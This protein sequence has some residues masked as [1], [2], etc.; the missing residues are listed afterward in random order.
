[1][2]GYSILKDEAG[3]RYKI[4]NN[5]KADFQLLV[6]M[7]KNEDFGT[8]KLNAIQDEILELYGKYVISQET[9]HKS[10]VN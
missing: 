6:K 7:A 8:L 3:K 2:I 5:L 9:K 10:T 4:P 1:M